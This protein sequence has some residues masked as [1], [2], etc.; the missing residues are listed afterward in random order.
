MKRSVWIGLSISVLAGLAQAASSAQAESLEPSNQPQDDKLQKPIIEFKP[1]GT[2]QLTKPDG[3]V[4]ILTPEEV[5]ALKFLNL[6]DPPTFDRSMP[7]FY[8]QR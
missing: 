5:E 7:C 2:Y 3:T 6:F 4:V 8:R 1:D